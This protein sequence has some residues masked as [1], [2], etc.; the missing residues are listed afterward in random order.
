MIE[1]ARNL[2]EERDLAE[3]LKRQKIEQRNSVN[4]FQQFCYLFL[5]KLWLVFPAVQFIYAIY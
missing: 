4:I 2:R 1:V 5:E 3:N